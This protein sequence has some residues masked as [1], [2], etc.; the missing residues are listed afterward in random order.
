MPFLHESLKFIPDSASR[1]DERFP[2]QDGS[3][4]SEENFIVESGFSDAWKEN[5]AYIKS[6]EE[7][8]GK[9]MNKFSFIDALGVWK[10]E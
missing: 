1:E 7:L 4:E 6:L 10:E 8:G 9:E 5:G 2:E 3:S